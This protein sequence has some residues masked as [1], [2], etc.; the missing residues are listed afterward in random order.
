MLI[1]G[2]SDVVERFGNTAGGLGRKC[3][4]RSFVSKS[5]RLL[6]VQYDV[7]GATT[8]GRISLVV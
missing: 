7:D 3:E 8:T 2:F 5:M 4:C 1:F 6:C